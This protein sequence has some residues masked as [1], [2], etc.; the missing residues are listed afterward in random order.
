MSG[1]NTDSGTVVEPAR[2]HEILGHHML[3]DGYPFVFDAKKSRG[4][5][6]IDAVTGRQYL[7]FFTFFASGS[8]GHNHPGLLEKKFYSRLAEIA[9]NKPS[10]SDIYSV[11]MAEFVDTFSRVAVPESMPHLFF[12]SGGA[13]A[14]EN[15]LKAAFDWKVQKNNMK[16]IKGD[17]GQ[18][19][20]H[21]RDAFHG[22]TGYTM[23][24]TNTDPAKIARFPKFDW[25]R[26]ENPKIIFPLEDNIEEVEAA[27]KRAVEAIER[28]LAQDGEDIAAIII[29]PIQGEG[30][31]NHFRPEFFK[32]LRRIADEKEV[33]L[34]FDE[35]QTGVGITGKMWCHQHFGVEPDILAFGK[36][37][38]VCGIM[39]SD[40]INE[41]D[42][43]FKVSSRINSTWGG[44]LVDMYRAKR[45]FEII[46]E[47][48]M[49]DNA[50]KMGEIFQ[51]HLVDLQAS[52]PDLLSSARGR[53]LFCA[54]DLPDPVVR[55]KVIS[56]LAEDG[57]LALKCGQRTV[58]FR[59]PLNV[60]KEEIDRAAEIIG[61]ALTKV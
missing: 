33:I 61:K 37:T 8:V 13:L 60:S 20:I 12:I 32:E 19:V 30:G 9:V 50:A 49:V 47:E 45:I 14:V 36:K 55:D 23:S 31:D 34:I 26:I 35:V 3:V 39:S 40:R 24:M 6:F 56:V 53:G 22:R 1:K 48:N 43:V 51:K 44:N 17:R 27:E 52:K 41:V 38:Q 58:R 18:K 29:E 15:A 25:P 16:G 21:F 2:V 28:V 11:E 57:L 46:E 42:S 5:Y 4:S 7:D 59:P 10:N 54:I